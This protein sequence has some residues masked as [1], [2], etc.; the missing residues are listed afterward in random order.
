[1]IIEYIRYEIPDAQADAF[2]TAYQRASE[3]MRASPHCLG[4]ELSRC[5]EEPTSF[6]LRIVWDSLQGHLEG[7]RKSPLFRPFLQAI[8]PYIG[9]IKEMRHYEATGLTWERGEG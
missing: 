8:Q 3:S 2:I 1:M 6:I 9:A 5:S 7:F 4:Y